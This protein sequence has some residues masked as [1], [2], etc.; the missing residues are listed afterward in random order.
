MALAERTR[1]ARSTPGVNHVDRVAACADN[2]LLCWQSAFEL[3]GGETHEL[4]T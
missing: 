1:E 2:D 4:S 3:K